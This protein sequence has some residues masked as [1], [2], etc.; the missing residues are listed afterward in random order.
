MGA[1]TVNP[2]TSQKPPESSWKP[3]FG[4]GDRVKHVKFGI[5]VVVACAPLK[6]DCEVT[7]A[8]PGVTGV[9]KLVQKLAKLEKV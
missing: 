9:K 6:D 2:P 1:Y 3:E 5:G 7:V 8:F 4:V